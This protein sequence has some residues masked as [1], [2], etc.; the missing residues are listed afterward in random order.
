MSGIKELLKRLDSRYQRIEQGVTVFRGFPEIINSHIGDAAQLLTFKVRENRPLI[1]VFAGA[2][3]TGKT[4]AT[5]DLETKVRERLEEQGINFTPGVDYLRTHPSLLPK[6]I[7]TTTATTFFLDEMAFSDR[8]TK[9][10]LKYISNTLLN[11]NNQKKLR[12]VLDIVNRTYE[13]TDPRNVEEAIAYLRQILP[14]KISEI[15]PFYARQ[16]SFIMIPPREVLG[17]IIPDLKVE[18]VA[19][20]LN[21]KPDQRLKEEIEYH[22]KR[23]AETIKDGVFLAGPTYIDHNQLVTQ[24]IH[25]GKPYS[26]STV[27]QFIRTPLI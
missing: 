21:L 6:T 10:L 24:L 14:L 2:E 22:K 7:P 16:D 18:T 4:T 17:K 25:T 9:Q 27:N 1:V 5:L 13:P 12:F 26:G 15:Y 23:V 11:P 8:T 20:A 19:A 3:R